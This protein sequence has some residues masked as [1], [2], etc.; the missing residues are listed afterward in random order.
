MVFVEEALKQTLFPHFVWETALT[1]TLNLG[2]SLS[3]PFKTI[4]Y[5]TN[6]QPQHSYL[7][8]RMIYRRS[9]ISLSNFPI[10]LLPF[11]TAES[12]SARN[13]LDKLWKTKE[14]NKNMWLTLL[15]ELSSDGPLIDSCFTAALLRSHEVPVSNREDMFLSQHP[16]RST[17]HIATS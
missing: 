15:P 8:N 13:E 11:P 9:D 16:E 3:N 1:V 17:S 14:K 6:Y 4:N 5:V 12:L 2:R 10:L 7:H